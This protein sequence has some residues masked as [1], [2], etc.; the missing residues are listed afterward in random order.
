[1]ARS[2]LWLIAV[3]LAAAHGLRFASGA[4]SAKLSMKEMNVIEYPLT[5]S[6][7]DLGLNPWRN[8][9]QQKMGEEIDGSGLVQITELFPFAR[10][11]RRFLQFRED[12]ADPVPNTDPRNSASTAPP[13]PP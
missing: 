5:G 6:W 2:L 11:G 3:L 9:P 8:R 4:G 13:P 12:Y 1:M 10:L 7:N